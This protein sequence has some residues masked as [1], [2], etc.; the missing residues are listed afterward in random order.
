MSKKTGTIPIKVHTT[1]INNG[2]IGKT[3]CKENFGYGIQFWLKK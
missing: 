1:P 2:I 3:K